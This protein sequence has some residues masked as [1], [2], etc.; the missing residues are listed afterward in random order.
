MLSP[1]GDQAGSAS[2]YVLF[3]SRST[4]EPSKLDTNISAV[5]HLPLAFL[6]VVYLYRFLADGTPVA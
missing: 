2:R 5:L 1:S 3:V 6:P 4:L